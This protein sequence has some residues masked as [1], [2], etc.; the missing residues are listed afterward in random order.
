MEPFEFEQRQAKEL[1]YSPQQNDGHM[2]KI[3]H[4]INFMQH[5][6]FFLPFQAFKKE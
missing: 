5:T 3:G 6:Y 1:S 2:S 4:A